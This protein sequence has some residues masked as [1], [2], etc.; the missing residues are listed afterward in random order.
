MSRDGV[1]PPGVEHSDP[2]FFDDT[3]LVCQC[4]HSYDEHATDGICL[5]PDCTCSMFEPADPAEDAE[6]EWADRAYD[7]MKEEGRL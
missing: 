1:L 7:A 2:H 5:D 6:L 4:E 3:D